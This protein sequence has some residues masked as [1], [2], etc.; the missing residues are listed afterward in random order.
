MAVKTITIDLEAY[1]LLARGKADGQSFS[2]VIKQHFGRQPTA[3]DFCARV[4][5]IRVSDEA[6]DAMDAQVRRRASEP[7]RA[8]RR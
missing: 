6:L 7:A 8:V 5:T 4:R 1:E 3:G 2:Q